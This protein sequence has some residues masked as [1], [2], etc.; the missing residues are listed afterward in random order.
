[1]SS[2]IRLESDSRDR[3]RVCMFHLRN[4]MARARVALAHECL[5]TMFADCLH[6]QVDLIGG[7]PNMALY[8]ARASSTTTSN[9]GLSHQRALICA[10]LR[11]NMFQPTVCVSS[12]NMRTNL[13]ANRT[14]SAHNRNGIPFQD[15]IH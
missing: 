4:T 12:N 15:L 11:Y 7:D 1:M 6:Y 5:G 14:G 3:I 10:I 9:R 13:E 8:R 2:L